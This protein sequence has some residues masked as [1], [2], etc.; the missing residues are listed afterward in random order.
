MHQIFLSRRN[1]LTL[2]SKLDRPESE[3]TL[4]KYRGAAKE[5]QQSCESILVT[6]VEDSVYYE[7]QKRIPGDVHPLDDPN[8]PYYEP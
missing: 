1:L 3:C 2:L 7:S 8:R 4:I 6:A 5:Y